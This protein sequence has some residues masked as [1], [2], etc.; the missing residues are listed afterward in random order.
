LAFQAPPNAGFLLT[1]VLTA[2][3]VACKSNTFFRSYRD[4]T[5]KKRRREK[6]GEDV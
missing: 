4:D 3:L 5:H 1:Y 6:K 2:K